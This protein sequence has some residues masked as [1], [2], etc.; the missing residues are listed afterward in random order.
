MSG[1]R[2]QWR[3]EQRSHA[4][5]ELHCPGQSVHPGQLRQTVT[6]SRVSQEITVGVGQHISQQPNLT[7]PATR[8]ISQP[9]FADP[10]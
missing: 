1:R 10:D 4:Q 6:T 5:A 7:S 3:G 9:V 2:R 8:K